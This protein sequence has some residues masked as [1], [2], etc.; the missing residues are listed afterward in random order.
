MRFAEKLPRHNRGS[1]PWEQVIVVAAHF[2]EQAGE[3]RMGL[4]R[5][6]G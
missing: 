6:H 5:I 3:K 1:H 4:V 2:V